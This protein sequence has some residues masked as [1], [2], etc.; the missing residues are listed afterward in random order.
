MSIKKQT[1]S[2]G[3]PAE[4]PTI[5]E[6]ATDRPTDLRRRHTIVPWFG[7]AALSFIWLTGWLDGG[8]LN[9]VRLVITKQNKCEGEGGNPNIPNFGTGFV[10]FCR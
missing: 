3:R 7:S 2:N 9:A 8:P 4:Q 1:T 6:R 10:L 5:R